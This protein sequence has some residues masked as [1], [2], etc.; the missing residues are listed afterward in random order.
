M[1]IL[2][3]S[4]FL[5]AIYNP[6]DSRHRE[7]T[8]LPLRPQDSFLVPTIILP[9]V[10]YLFRRDLGYGGLRAFLHKLARIHPQLEPLPSDDLPR[11]SEIANSYEDSRFDLVDCCI[12]AMAER[13]DITRVATFDRRDFGMFRPRHCAFL[14]LLP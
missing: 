10:S 13:L 1:M 2:I 9:E 4:S 14:E 5:Y 8:A 6:Q 3:D 11:I 12:M 7:A